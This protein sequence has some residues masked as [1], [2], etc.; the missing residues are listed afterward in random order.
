MFGDLMR[1]SA[2]LALGAAT[3]RLLPL[4]VLVVA[5]RQLESRAFASA[6][7]GFAWAG[8]AMCLTGSGLATVMTQRLGS[9]ASQ[10]DRAA[11]FSR[12]ARPALALSVVLALLLLLFGE[13]FGSQLFGTALDSRVVVPAALSGAMWSLVAMVVSALNGCHRAR[14][15]SILLAVCGLLQG[16]GMAGGLLSGADAAGMVWGLAAGSASAALLAQMFLRHALGMSGALALWRRAP[17]LIERVPLMRSAVLWNSLAAASVLPISF[18]AGSLVARAG[19]DGTRELAQYFALEQVHQALVYAPAIVGTA[20]L[21]MFARHFGNRSGGAQT[22]ALMRRVARLSMGAALVGVSLAAA[23]MFDADWFVRALGNPA[24]Q[25]QDVWAVRWMTL[26]AGLAL[27]LS[28]LGGMLLGAGRIVLASSLNLV[29]GA[30]FLVLTAA[31]S[32]YGNQGLQLSR[33]LASMALGGVAVFAL[34]ELARRA[35]RT[36]LQTPIS[37]TTSS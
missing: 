7:A 4:V 27:S 35:M 29:Y 5:S 8:V 14:A 34:L 24:L 17:G 10:A 9:Y 26:N 22:A 28:L 12:H 2:W 15:A 36:D 33:L 3:G 37:S 30:I 19:D 16:A 13:R 31:L 20:L 11:I 1:R 18:M 23:L 6:S 32:D 25:T 21:P